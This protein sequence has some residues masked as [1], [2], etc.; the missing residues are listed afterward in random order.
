[1]PRGGGSVAAYDEGRQ[2]AGARA[3]LRVEGDLPDLTGALLVRVENEP[4][5]AVGSVPWGLPA[6]VVGPAG[7]SPETGRPVVVQARDAHRHPD[8]LA[9][10]ADLAGR[11][12]VVLVDYGWPAPLT[13][14]VVRVVTHGGSRPTYAAVDE[15]LRARGW[16]P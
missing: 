12:P 16:R 8:V 14:P 4:N 13:V 10:L 11:V 6:Q 2:R 5:I 15:L 3:A 9:L 1:V 7:L